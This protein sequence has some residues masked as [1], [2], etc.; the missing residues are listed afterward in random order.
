MQIVEV[1]QAAEAWIDNAVVC[2]VIAEINRQRRVDGGDPDRVD[3]R[4]DKIVEPPPD[5]HEV[6]D[7]VVIG[8]L[9]GTWVHPPATRARSCSSQSER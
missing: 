6:A 2:D 5:P 4:A 9:K 7:A 1:C 8:V 3:P